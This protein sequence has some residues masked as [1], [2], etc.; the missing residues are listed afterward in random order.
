MATKTMDVEKVRAYIRKSIGMRF[1]TLTAYADKED[2]TLQYIS[3]V[4][5]GRK[6]IPEWMYKRFG[7]RHVVTE[8]WEL[9]GVK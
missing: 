8:H 7:I 6:P 5:A 4:L 3:T 1:G 9:A 2:V